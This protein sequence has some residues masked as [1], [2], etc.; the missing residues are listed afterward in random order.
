MEKGVRTHRVVK[1]MPHKEK[2]DLEDD[3]VGLR[4]CLGCEEA[5]LS[6]WKGNRI[7][8]SCSIHNSNQTMPYDYLI[9]SEELTDKIGDMINREEDKQDE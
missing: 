8:P 6:S 2:L 4:K 7:C 9:M 3:E 5:F 1:G